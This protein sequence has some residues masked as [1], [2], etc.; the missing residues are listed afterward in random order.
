MSA[1]P[2]L[3][4]VCLCAAWCGTCREYEAAF[5]ELQQGAPGHRYRWIDIEDEAEL[6]GDID[7]ETFPTLMVAWQGRVLFAGPVLPRVGDAQRLLA[8]QAERAAAWQARGEVPAQPALGV[9]EDQVRAYVAL[10]H[11]LG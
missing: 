8:V 4:V 6:V 3:D 5:A 10:A 2:V 9:P 1:L 7:V 11:Q